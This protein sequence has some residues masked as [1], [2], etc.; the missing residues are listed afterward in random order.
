MLGWGR[1][2]WF[3]SR[4]RLCLQDRLKYALDWLNYFFRWGL[5]KGFFFHRVCSNCNF[6]PLD[7][8]LRSYVYFNFLSK[9]DSVL[10]MLFDV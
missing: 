2:F 5:M 1:Q 7:L 3:S 4:F 10:P 6:Y 8:D 9:I